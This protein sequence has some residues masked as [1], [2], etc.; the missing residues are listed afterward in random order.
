MV[1]GHPLCRCRSAAIGRAKRPSIRARAIS[2][3]RNS[4]QR[5]HP[6]HRAD[7]YTVLAVGANRG[8]RCPSELARQLQSN[9]LI[10]DVD[11]AGAPLV[12]TDVLV[13][14]GGGA[15]CAAA[16][17]A[18]Q[19]RR[20][21]D[22]RHQAAAGR[23]QHGDGRGRH[24]GGGRRRRQP[25]AHFE[26]TLRA[27]HFCADRELVAQMVMD[28]PDVIRWLIQLGVLFDLGDDRPIGGN[29]LRKKAGGASVARILSYRDYTGLEM[30]RVLREAVDL[31]P[32]IDVWNRCPAVE[33][34][35]DDL[36]RM[37]RRRDLQS[38]MAQLRPGARDGRDSRHGR[39]RAPASE[40]ISRPR[41][42]SARPPTAWCSPIGSAH[43]F[44]NSI[45]SSTIRPASPIHRTSRAV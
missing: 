29:L 6:D 26:D 33:L 45:P 37:R 5:Y 35:S 21:G 7:A 1:G 9:T 25:A 23:Q 12:Y 43:A 30:M 13:V 39:Q 19:S 42:I 32:M 11:I 10:D 3:F 14:G 41:T 17:V 15:G 2:R 31:E 8:E 20:E 40:P 34:L 44:A 18:A 27:G 24:P 22:P 16:L 4:S 28:G 38:R 36:W